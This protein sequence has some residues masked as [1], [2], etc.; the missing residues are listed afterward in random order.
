L[1]KIEQI[2]QTFDD[3]KRNNGGA[4]GYRWFGSTVALSPCNTAF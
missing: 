3:Q 2:S 1:Q 4:Y